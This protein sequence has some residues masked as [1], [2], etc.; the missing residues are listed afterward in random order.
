[1]APKAK[2]TTADNSNAARKTR[3]KAAEVPQEVVKVPPPRTRA[4]QEI[5]NGEAK[6]LGTEYYRQTRSLKAASFAEDREWA[7]KHGKDYIELKH[8]KEVHS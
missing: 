2:A 4:V 1:M 8:G 3:S 7:R 6:M 5:P